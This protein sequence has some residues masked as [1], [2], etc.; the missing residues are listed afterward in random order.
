MIDWFWLDWFYSF[1]PTSPFY[2]N[3]AH[4]KEGTWIRAAKR[5]PENQ[6]H[7]TACNT[8]FPSNRTAGILPRPGSRSLG[9]SLT[10]LS[11]ASSNGTFR[12]VPVARVL[13]SGSWVPSHVA[14]SFHQ[15]FSPTLPSNSVYLNKCMARAGR[16]PS[17]LVPETR[18]ACRTEINDSQ[19]VYYR[20]STWY[21]LSHIA[22]AF[23]NIQTTHVLCKPTKKGGKDNP[24]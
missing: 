1:T 18:R 22:A 11:Q 13:W 21:I 14:Q 16:P 19:S 7:T 9:I 20:L 24:K 3:L 4:P 2:R 5:E 15:P 17:L 23:Y 6:I 8:G 10:K 12:T